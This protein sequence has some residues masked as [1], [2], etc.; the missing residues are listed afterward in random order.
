MTD[1]EEPLKRD[2]S[3]TQLQS[4]KG[5]VWKMVGASLVVALVAMFMPAYAQ[6]SRNAQL[7]PTLVRDLWCALPCIPG[8]DALAALGVIATLILGVAV[9]RY[10]GS[11]NTG[12]F[13][14]DPMES[15]YAEFAQII[16]GLATLASWWVCLASAKSGYDNAGVGSPEIAASIAAVTAL[17]C[18]VA[19]AL[20]PDATLY[21]LGRAQL[22]QL[23]Q[24]KQELDRRRVRL[25]GAQNDSPADRH[26]RCVNPCC[27]SREAWRWLYRTVFFGGSPGAGWAAIIYAFIAGLLIIFNRRGVGWALFLA[28]LL[29][30][31]LTW[32]FG[33]IV[34]SGVVSYALFVPPA[35]K[36]RK[37]WGSREKTFTL[38]GVLAVFWACLWFYV[39]IEHYSGNILRP[40]VTFLF[41]NFGWIRWSILFWKLGAWVDRIQGGST[42]PPSIADLKYR[43]YLD[44]QSAFVDTRI[45]D[46]KQKEANTL[47]N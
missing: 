3:E 45:R 15:A 1:Q 47:V 24:V 30:A 36:P 19:Y 5:S 42:E 13:Q 28:L 32:I 7:S 22:D 8:A 18:A 9:G 25:V 39:L 14:T 46:L 2:A 35:E 4:I 44:T 12:G 29:F 41:L 17:I 20:V 11:K 33:R 27:W 26:G 40:V 38:A 10:A 16:S 21:A 23:R 34:L 37:A 31:T 43:E 6:A